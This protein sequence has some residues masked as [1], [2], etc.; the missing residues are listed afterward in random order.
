MKA[1]LLVNGGRGPFPPSD[2]LLA[3]LKEAVDA[4]GPG[5]RVAVSRTLE[6]A[7]ELTE[8][9]ARQGYDALWMG[10]GDGTI[11]VL[12]NHAFGRGM[13]LGV[14]P[15]GTVNAL[16]R[17]LG[18]P[19]NPV[20]AAWSL[21]RARPLPFDV[22][23]VAGR[24]FVCFASIGFDAAVVHDVGGDFKRYWGRVAY[25]LAGL[26]A[27]THPERLARFT[28][29]FD[30]CSCEPPAPCSSD[31]LYPGREVCPTQEGYNLVV[32]KI[33]NY[34][35]LPLFPNVAP[36]SGLME[37]WLFHRRRPD[38]LFGWAGGATS[39]ELG[40]P[41]RRYFGR[42]V[43]HFMTPGFTVRSENP[44]FL[45]VDGEAITPENPHEL[46]FTCLHSAVQLLVPR[47]TGVW[48]GGE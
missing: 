8:E 47:Q 22:G 2:R 38:D 42:S 16:A 37:T 4:A 28:V 35:G 23:E 14:V 1:F 13:A 29:E 15:M 6:E 20:A 31:L 33:C 25:A 5:G 9:A 39:G 44:L 18:I 32:S 24:K 46:R 19:L 7:E 48:E 21:A 41:V 40:V 26:R 17:T 27:L 12:L 36:C 45:Q 30:Q 43:G 3:R 11:H 10:G 34:A